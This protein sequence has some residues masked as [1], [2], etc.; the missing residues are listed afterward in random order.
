MPTTASGAV[1]TQQSKFV[2]SVAYAMG[3]TSATGTVT[4]TATALESAI[5]GGTITLLGTYASN[6]QV[7]WV[8]GGTIAPKYRPSS[9]K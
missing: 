4:A 2:S 7:D 6:G 9:C 1:D 3:S 5:A 8:C